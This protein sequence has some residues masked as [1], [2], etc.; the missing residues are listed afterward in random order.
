MEV[1]RVTAHSDDLIHV[2]GKRAYRVISFI[3]D[4]NA[5]RV[6]SVERL[7]DGAVSDRVGKWHLQQAPRRRVSLAARSAR[8]GQAARQCDTQLVGLPL[9]GTHAA[10]SL[11]YGSPML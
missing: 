10:S 4:G 6:H 2:D 8:C 5:G 11:A 1:S 9:W 7:E 3:G